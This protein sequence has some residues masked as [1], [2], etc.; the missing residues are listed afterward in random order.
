M[1]NLEKI[2]EEHFKDHIDAF[3]KKIKDENFSVFF[4]HCSSV[5]YEHETTLGVTY[6]LLTTFAVNKYLNEFIEP[7]FSLKIPDEDW[8]CE[9][10]QL[11][12]HLNKKIL[13]EIDFKHLIFESIHKDFSVKLHRFYVNGLIDQ[14]GNAKANG[15]NYE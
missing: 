4:K 11:V 6:K 8:N 13:N 3:C 5:T 10:I 12:H 15:V 2:S 14:Y 7:V 1:T 9:F